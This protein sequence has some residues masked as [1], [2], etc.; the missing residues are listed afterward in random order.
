MVLVE[1]I[2]EDSPPRSGNPNQQN[3]DHNDST[4]SGPSVGIAVN[5][6]LYI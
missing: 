4:S 6:L 3:Q 2:T 1:D 5:N